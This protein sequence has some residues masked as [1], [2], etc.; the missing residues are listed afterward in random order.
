MSYGELDI[1]MFLTTF[2]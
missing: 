2:K 1:K